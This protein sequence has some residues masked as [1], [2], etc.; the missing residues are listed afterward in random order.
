[1]R[2]ALWRKLVPLSSGF[3][4]CTINLALS[5]AQYCSLFLKATSLTYFYTF[6]YFDPLL[7]CRIVRRGGRGQALPD[8]APSFRVLS[9]M[10][11]IAFRNMHFSGFDRWSNP[12]ET[13]CQKF[14][15]VFV[16]SLPP[17]TP[18]N[19]EG[20]GALQ[21]ITGNLKYFDKIGTYLGRRWFLQYPYR[22]LKESDV[23]FLP[24]FYLL[25]HD[26]HFGNQLL[27]CDVFFRHLCN[28]L[29]GKSNIKDGLEHLARAECMMWKANSRKSSKLFFAVKKIHG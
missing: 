14:I 20:M 1:M 17:H 23:V 11:I 15:G 27:W 19:E 3:M 9:L 16:A 2:F 22:I 25:R 18:R 28:F 24:P 4:A 21:S 26:G 5:P 29:S 13:Y 12:S 10:T 8:H 7:A 6:L